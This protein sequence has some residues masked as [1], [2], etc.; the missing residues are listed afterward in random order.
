M[1]AQRRLLGKKKFLLGRKMNPGYLIIS[2]D[3]LIKQEDAS[4]CLPA[5]HKDADRGGRRLAQSAH[6]YLFGDGKAFVHKV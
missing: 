6:K 2:L 4:L 3:S 5:S 1:A